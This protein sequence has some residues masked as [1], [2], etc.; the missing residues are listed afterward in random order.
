MTSAAALKEFG[1]AL[2]A[3]RMCSLGEDPC[4]GSE[5]VLWEDAAMLKNAGIHVVDT[6]SL[7]HGLKGKYEIDLFPAGGVHWNAIGIAAADDAILAEINRQAGSAI[8]LALPSLV[9]E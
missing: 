6:A 8:A 5:V 1:V 4:G 9:L 2:L 7:M 3:P